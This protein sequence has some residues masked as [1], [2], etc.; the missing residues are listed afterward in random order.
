MPDGASGF[1]GKVVRDIVSELWDVFTGMAAF[2]IDPET[3]IRAEHLTG[4]TPIHVTWNIDVRSM[5]R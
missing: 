4:D 2:E 1:Y 5:P 3:N